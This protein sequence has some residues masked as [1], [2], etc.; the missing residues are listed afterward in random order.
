[1]FIV[2]PRLL[3][4]HSFI[5]EHSKHFLQRYIKTNIE[6]SPGFFVKDRKKKK[7][8]AVVNTCNVLKVSETGYY[9]WKRILLRL[10]YNGSV[11]Y[12]DI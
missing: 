11:F 12:V 4:V 8:F 6:R 9:K 10:F 2:Q 3:F 7:K 1:M 5:L